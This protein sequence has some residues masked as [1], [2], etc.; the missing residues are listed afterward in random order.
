VIH[1]KLFHISTAFHAIEAIMLEAILGESSFAYRRGLSRS[2]WW[3]DVPPE[4]ALQ[5]I[6]A[7]PINVRVFEVGGMYEVNYFKMPANANVA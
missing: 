2:K 3:L 5:A 4:L 1:V 6:R 7:D